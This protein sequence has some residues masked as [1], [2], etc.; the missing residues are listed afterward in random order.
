MP[1]TSKEMIRLLISYGFNKAGRNQ[2]VIIA[3]V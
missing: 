2:R 3:E 1:I